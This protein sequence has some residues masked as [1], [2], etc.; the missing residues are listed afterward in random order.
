MPACL[1]HT[2]HTVNAAKG[3]SAEEGAIFTF[4]LPFLK[5]QIILTIIYCIKATQGGGRY[6]CKELYIFRA[7]STTKLS[8][9]IPLTGDQQ[10]D[11]DILAFVQARQ[12]LLNRTGNTHTHVNRKTR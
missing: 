5:S 12:N 9:S 1:R 4:T 3:A 6:L 8:S 7:L 2:E 11:A 10:T